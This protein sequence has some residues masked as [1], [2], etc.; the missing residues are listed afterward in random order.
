MGALLAIAL[1]LQSDSSII[2]DLD[3]DDIEVRDAATRTLA[4]RGTAA[5]DTLLAARPES[6]DGCLRV[7]QLLEAVDR[8]LKWLNT[9]G[10]PVSDGLQATLRVDR[11]TFTVGETIDLQLD[12]ANVAESKKFVTPIGRVDVEFADR[13]ERLQDHGTRLVVRR[14]SH[15]SRKICEELCRKME[16]QP[17]VPLMPRERLAKL[18]PIEARGGRLF[19]EL[20]K[21]EEPEPAT[22]EPG[23]YEL[24]AVYHLQEG[25]E[26]RSNVVRIRIER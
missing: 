5:R 9:P 18:I 17:A 6:G 13:A 7:R 22:L 12:I 16:L 2:R 10:G 21:G 1:A 3:H 25:V 26:L 24:E 20:R 19:K 11:E 4:A 23:E 8:R 15:E 14:L